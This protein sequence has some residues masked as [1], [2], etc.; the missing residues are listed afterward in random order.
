[1]YPVPPVEYYLGTKPSQA[2]EASTLLEICSVADGR[3]CCGGNDR[4]DAR[5]RHQTPAGFMF[6]CR[7]Q[8]DRIGLS[9][10]T[11]QLT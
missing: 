1:M 10:L 9:D 3:D 7:P 11:L 6:A 5:D 2:G 4:S 8:N